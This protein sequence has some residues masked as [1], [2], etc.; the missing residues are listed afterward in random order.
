[1]IYDTFDDSDMPDEYYENYSVFDPEH[2]G[3]KHTLGILL[4]ITF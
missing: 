3:V 4:D 2:K 1:M